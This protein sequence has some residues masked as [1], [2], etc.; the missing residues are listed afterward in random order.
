MILI[1][2]KI[3]PQKNSFLQSHPSLPVP[4]VSTPS[5]KLSAALMWRK[6]FMNLRRRH[7]RERFGHAL[8]RPKGSKILRSALLQAALLLESAEI[9]KYKTMSLS[10]T[11]RE[12][13][14]W[15]DQT[16]K[17]WSYDFW[18]LYLAD[19]PYVFEPNFLVLS[20][21]WSNL[22]RCDARCVARCPEAHTTILSE[23]QLTKR[24]LSSF[25]MIIFFLIIF[26]F[27]FSFFNW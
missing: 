26:F 22:Q 9:F 23:S 8:N 15:F 21:R 2:K 12:C 19:L 1:S 4:S 11:H 13:S 24:V 17:W 5:N 25:Q 27:L 10:K 16:R 18:N 3:P 20:F 6:L 7:I 14:T